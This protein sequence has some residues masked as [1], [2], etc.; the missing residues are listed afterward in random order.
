MLGSDYE[1]HWLSNNGLQEFIKILCSALEKCIAY[2]NVGLFFY[3]LRLNQTDK[4]NQVENKNVD[5]Y[6]WAIIQ[7]LTSEFGQLAL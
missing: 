4:E 2:L 5:Y 6:S 7:F 3:Y 1:K